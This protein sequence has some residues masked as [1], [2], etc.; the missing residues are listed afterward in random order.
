MHWAS[1]DRVAIEK[2]IVSD[3]IYMTPYDPIYICWS[4]RPQLRGHGLTQS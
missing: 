4:V 3:P 1:N 2:T